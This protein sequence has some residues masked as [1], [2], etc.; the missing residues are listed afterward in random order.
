MMLLER[1]DVQGNRGLYT[2]NYH[3]FADMMEEIRS[4]ATPSI[5]Q[6]RPYEYHNEHMKQVFKRNSGR[7]QTQMM[8]TVNLIES[9]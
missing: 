2:L 3:L 6:S 7:I 5:L 8:E 9:S 1:F 4:L